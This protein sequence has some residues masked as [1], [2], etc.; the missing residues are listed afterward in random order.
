M[1]RS[2]QGI[3]SVT[4]VMPNPS[5]RIE[6]KWWFNNGAVGSYG[7]ITMPFSELLDSHDWFEHPWAVTHEVLHGF[8]YP[9]GWELNRV[10]Y[11]VQ[12]MFENFRYYVADH[13]EYVP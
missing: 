10:D 2:F 3:L 9:H 8:G 6:I 7:G 4:G 5:Y 13:P 12:D 1:E 11:I